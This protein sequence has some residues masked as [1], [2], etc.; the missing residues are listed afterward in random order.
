M[1]ISPIKL[2][3][4]NYLSNALQLDL[5]RALWKIKMLRFILHL[6]I[7][8]DETTLSS[9]QYSIIQITHVLKQLVTGVRPICHPYRTVPYP[10]VF[11]WSVSFQWVTVYCTVSFFILFF[12]SAISTVIGVN[13]FRF[14]S[15]KHKPQNAKHK[16]VFRFEF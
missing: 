7:I 2:K 1:M 5:I 8:Q 11:Y 13:Y 15:K 10:I 16:S 3:Y 14:F 9:V 12:K 6:P 4:D